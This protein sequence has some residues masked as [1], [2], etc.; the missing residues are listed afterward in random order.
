MYIVDIHRKQTQ[1]VN[2][3]VKQM[4]KG[5]RDLSNHVDRGSMYWEEYISILDELPGSRVSLFLTKSFDPKMG[6]TDG[7][8]K[9]EQWKEGSKEEGVSY[10]AE[11]KFDI[12][13]LVWAF[14]RRYQELGWID[15][16][17][18]HRNRLDT[19]ANLIEQHHSKEKDREI[20]KE[21]IK[22]AESLV[23]V[24]MYE[25]IDKALVFLKSSQKHESNGKGKTKDK[26]AVI[27]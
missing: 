2:T 26:E 14:S 13:F 12:H 19:L 9:C 8:I 21:L 7:Y 1:K 20:E 16:A 17:V 22:A 23:R 11:V 3:G 24:G 18:F 25:D 5:T 6:T 15:G 27:P 10:K 4:P